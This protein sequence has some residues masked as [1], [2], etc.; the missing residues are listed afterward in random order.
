MKYLSLL[1]ATILLFHFSAFSQNDST[2]LDLGSS[3]LNRHFAQTVSIKGA[4][5]EK[6]PFA[7]LSEAINVWL[8][9]TY[10]SN[11]VYITYVVDGNITI[12]VNTYSV[13]DIEEVALVQNAMA[14]SQVG[15]NQQQMVLITTRR[16]KGK[17]GMQAAAQT[18]LVHSPGA[19]TNLYHQYY[20]GAYKQ[21]DKISV[22]LSANYL[23]DV[24][25]ITRTD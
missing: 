14:S 18:F 3:V 5:L 19:H 8:Y 2:R 24:V 20:V 4:D 21:M 11:P 12:D 1:T 7:S 13:H 23:R 17:Q 16:G 25:P 15:N 10:S 6:M 22:G 9:G